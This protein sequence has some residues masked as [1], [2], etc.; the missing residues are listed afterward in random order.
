MI[1]RIYK[2]R[3]TVVLKKRW[4]E[5]EGQEVTQLWYD[6]FHPEYTD[7]K[8]EKISQVQRF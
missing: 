8:G 2:R 5:K 3:E 1:F 7:K 4:K 6:C